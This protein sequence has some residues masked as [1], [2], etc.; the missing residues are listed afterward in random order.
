[1]TSSTWGAQLEK[2][3]NWKNAICPGQSLLL[4]DNS[5]YAKVW[6]LCDRQAKQL[7]TSSHTWLLEC[8]H[9]FK[10]ALIFESIKWK[11]NSLL[12]VVQYLTALQCFSFHCFVFWIIIHFHLVARGSVISCFSSACHSHY[13]QVINSPI[14]TFTAVLPILSCLPNLIQQCSTRE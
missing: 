13:L 2:G 8:C 11:E 6:T 14:S 9:V 10:V 5:S 4:R 12:A 7:E 3:L 1:M